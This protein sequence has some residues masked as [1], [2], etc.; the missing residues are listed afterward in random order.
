MRLELV[1][2]GSLT[3]TTSACDQIVTLDCGCHCDGFEISTSTGIRGY[4]L[5]DPSSTMS[6]WSLR[7]R[8]PSQYMPFHAVGPTMR[9]WS[10]DYDR[11]SSLP[12][13]AHADAQPSVAPGGVVAAVD[14]KMQ[15]IPGN[16][17]CCVTVR[18]TGRQSSSIDQDMLP[19]LG[20]SVHM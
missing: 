18:S 5:D 14:T 13:N 2:W 1:M 6:Y 4:S 20:K 19:D 8:C 3:S 17:K 9:N 7:H 16:Q 15:H 10:E 11:V 12:H